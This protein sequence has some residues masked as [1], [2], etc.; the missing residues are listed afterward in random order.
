MTGLQLPLHVLE[1]LRGT[2][3]VVSHPVEQETPE[4]QALHGTEVAWGWGGVRGGSRQLARK[5]RGIL[6]EMAQQSQKLATSSLQV[7]ILA[8]LLQ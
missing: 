8:M 1:V 5:G 7:T 3:A 2:V 6:N 4:S